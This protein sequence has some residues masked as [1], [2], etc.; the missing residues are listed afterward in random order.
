MRRPPKGSAKNKKH[1]TPLDELAQLLAPASSSGSPNISLVENL[2][3]RI[4]HEFD[5]PHSFMSSEQGIRL[6]RH[7]S[8][9]MGRNA[10]GYSGESLTHSRYA[11]VKEAV[12]SDSR[13]A[14]ALWRQ[15]AQRDQSS[16]QAGHVI[17]LLI[18]ADQR[19]HRCS[20]LAHPRLRIRFIHLLWRRL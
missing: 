2:L 18:L 17:L 11:A 19:L 3:L 20:W 1:T 10:G 16:L 4:R 8:S 15:L 7:L 12:S 14:D 9:G 5:S 6:L 13:L